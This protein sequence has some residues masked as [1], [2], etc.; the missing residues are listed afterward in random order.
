MNDYDDK[1]WKGEG[2]NLEAAFNQAWHN[3]NHDGAPAGTYKVAIAIET[4]NPIRG[5]IV[6]ITQDD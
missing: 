6:T 3:A 2:A 1:S 5:Y 4:E